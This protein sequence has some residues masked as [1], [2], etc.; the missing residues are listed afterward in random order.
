MIHTQGSASLHP[1][2]RVLRAS[3]TFFCRPSGTLALKKIPQTPRLR[4][5]LRICRGSATKNNFGFACIWLDHDSQDFQDHERI[6]GSSSQALGVV[7]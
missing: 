2:L 7:Q 1:G 4:T 5:G 3:G 6:F